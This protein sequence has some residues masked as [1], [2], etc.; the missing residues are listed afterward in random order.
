MKILAL[1]N[2]YPPHF[3]GGY[4]LICETVVKEL[5]KRGHIIQLLTSNHRLPG[6]PDGEENGIERSL[7]IHGFYGHPWLGILKLRHLERENNRLLKAAITR[8]KPDLVYVLTMGGLSKSI[9][10]PL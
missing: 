9:R 8:F 7:R 1:T 3:L 4:E 5:R 10:L 2:L 6:V